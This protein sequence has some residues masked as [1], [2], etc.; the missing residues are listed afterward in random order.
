MRKL[1]DDFNTAYDY[2]KD[3]LSAA[4]VECVSILNEERKKESPNQSIIDKYENELQKIFA[5]ERELF[6][7]NPER[8]QEIYDDYRQFV[9][10]HRGLWVIQKIL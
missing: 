7:C 9:R 8:M 6:T 3:T 10:S 2:V 5:V 1:P 4:T